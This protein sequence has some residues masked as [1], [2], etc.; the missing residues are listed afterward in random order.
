MLKSP[1][2]SA[3]EGRARE[4]KGESGSP[5]GPATLPGLPALGLGKILEV[6]VQQAQR[7][8]RRVQRYLE[9]DARHARQAPCKAGELVAARTAVGGRKAAGDFLQAQHIGAAGRRT[10]GLDVPAEEAEHG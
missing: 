2:S 9:R 3:A 8:G 10:R 6:N 1:S 5:P 7:A 4:A